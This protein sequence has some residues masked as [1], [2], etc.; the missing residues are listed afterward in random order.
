MTIIFLIQVTRLIDYVSHDDY[1]D[2]TGNVFDDER[3]S[4]QLFSLTV[5]ERTR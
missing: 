1:M 2:T 5:K 4:Q 3:T